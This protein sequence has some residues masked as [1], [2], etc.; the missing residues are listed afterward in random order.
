M[1]T[2]LL[3]RDYGRTPRGKKRQELTQI[4]WGAWWRPPPNQPRWQTKEAQFDARIRAAMRR[5]AAG[6]VLDG[7]AAARLWGLPIMGHCDVI[8]VVTTVPHSRHCHHWGQGN[9]RI[10]VKP[11]SRTIPSDAITTHR[12]IRVLKPEYLCAELLARQPDYI[13]IPIVEAALHRLISPS[14][15]QRQRVIAAFQKAKNT[16]LSI[17]NNRR[18]KRGVKRA[19]RLL[20]RISPW[21]ESVGESRLRMLM[22]EL[23]LPAPQQ[24]WP[25]A[26]ERGWI[27]PDFA[28]PDHGVAI[29]FDGLEKYAKDAPRTLQAEKQ[30]E[31]SLR[32]VFPVIMRFLWQDLNTGRARY[33]LRKLA[34]RFASLPPPPSRLTILPHS[35]TEDVLGST[36]KTP[37]TNLKPAANECSKTAKYALQQQCSAPDCDRIPQPLGQNGNAGQ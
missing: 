25:V 7:I 16:L 37:T 12:G 29:E 21:S 2:K 30:R 10:T 18:W 35:T 23:Q 9:E 27:W 8:E 26:T 22:E 15:L 6:T 4:L 3:T 28:W 13:A 17:L 34:H 11:S 14:P 32:P 19:Q 1:E 20:D 31:E 33:Q 36:L 24:Q 5:L